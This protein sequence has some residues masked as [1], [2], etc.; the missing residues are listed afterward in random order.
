MSPEPPGPN[1]IEPSSDYRADRTYGFRYPG[2]R[3]S[4]AGWWPS[5]WTIVRYEGDGNSAQD[6]PALQLC[7]S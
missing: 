7:G 4:D 5:I 2:Y 3:Q 1:L 6:K